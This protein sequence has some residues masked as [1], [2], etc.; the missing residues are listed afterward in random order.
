MDKIIVYVDDAAYARQLLAPMQTHGSA[1]PGGPDTHWVVVA[2]APRITHRISKWVS[3][4]A[5]ESWRAKWSEKLF[6]EVAPWLQQRGDR[7]TPV[8]AKGALV[9]LTPKLMAEHGATRVLDARRPKLGQDMQ[10][11]T[12]NQP[13]EQQSPWAMPGT[14]AGMGIMLL[15]AS[16]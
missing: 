3:H 10:P 7:M 14:V 12:A 16:D 1:G 15:L 2:C 4:S 9:E 6:A 11:V 8:L 5:R 13:A